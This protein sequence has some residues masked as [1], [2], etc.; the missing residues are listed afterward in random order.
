M[1]YIFD[2]ILVL[3]TIYALY[4]FSTHLCAIY[5][6]IVYKN[7]LTFKFENFAIN[8]KT[9][10]ENRILLKFIKLIYLLLL[11][12]YYRFLHLNSWIGSNAEKID[13]P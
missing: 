8:L 2:S 3:A 11:E 7:H 4:T 6:P 13:N 5:N 12:P 1:H 10:R 9:Q